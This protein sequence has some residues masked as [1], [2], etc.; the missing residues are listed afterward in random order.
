M[1][2]YKDVFSDQDELL[3]DT[4]RVEPQ[5]GGAIFK[6]QGKMKTEKTVVD[7]SMFGG[8]ASA[9]GADA[10]A[11]AD[12]AVT[13]GIDVVLEY[14]LQEYTITKGDYKT[15]IKDYMKKLREKI[16][17]DTPDEEASFTKGATALVKDVLGDFK[18]WSFYCGESMNCEGMLVPCK[19]E[20]DDTVPCFFF[21]K[22]GLIREKV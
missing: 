8:N 10:D 14:R 18:N 15:Y 9:D 1:I 13:S 7:D 20:E 17:K 4:Y 16:A 12:D 6:V 21:F 19:W 3:S 22:H 2:I 5:H 11:G